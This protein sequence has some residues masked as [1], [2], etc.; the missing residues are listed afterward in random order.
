MNIKEFVDDLDVVNGATLRINCPVCFGLN[1]FTVSNKN[2]MLMWNCYKAGCNIRGGARTYLSVED[3]RKSITVSKKTAIKWSKPDYVV[4]G[5]CNKDMERFINEWSLQGMASKLLYDVKEHRIVFPIYDNRYLV[6]GAG[7]SLGK[8][9][10]K[11][12]RYGESGL[13]YKYGSHNI[14]VIVEDA[15]SAALIGLS[16]KA[17]G[18][19][20]LGTSLQDTHKEPIRQY[21]KLIVAL[22]PDALPKTLMIAQELRSIHSNVSVLRLIDDLKYKNDEDINNLERLLWS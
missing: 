19:A 16:G 17:T 11:W 21:D 13:P 10:P 1:T 8:R 18:V 5:S 2:G 4:R 20:L 22:D 15:I 3:I 9:L 7:R 12:K 14:A 6:D